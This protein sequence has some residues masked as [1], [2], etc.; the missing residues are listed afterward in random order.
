MAALMTV[1]DWIASA[2][3]ERAAAERAADMWPPWPAGEENARHG[4]NHSR[5]PRAQMTEGDD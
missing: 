3:E 2:R 5:P 4:E 1:E